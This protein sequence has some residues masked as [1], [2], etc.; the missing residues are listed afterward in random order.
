MSP[1]KIIYPQTVI[2][3]LAAGSSSRLGSPKQLLKWGDT[4][5]L[6]HAIDQATKANPKKVVVVLGANHDLIRSKTNRQNVE[7]LINKKWE[8]GMGGSISTGFSF[9]V[10]I[11]PDAENILIML[12][13]QPAVNHHYLAQLMNTHSSSKQ[14]IIA[15]NYN[16]KPGVP[17]MFR[18]NSFNVLASMNNKGGA[19]KL[20]NDKVEEVFLVSPGFEIEDID[21]EE[22]YLRLLAYK[23]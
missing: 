18:R 2:I 11:Y 23:T 22:D 21:T 13:D 16:G 4:T 19:K 7:Y 6:E 12:C 17:A 20:M 10:D 1:E 15:T 14:S 3:I 5:L 9:V 8:A